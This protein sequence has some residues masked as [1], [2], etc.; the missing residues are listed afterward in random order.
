MNPV[1][2]HVR[3]DGFA[4]CTLTPELNAR[5]RTGP[6]NLKYD[7]TDG[8]WFGTQESLNLW[9]EILDFKTFLRR[10]EQRNRA[11]FSKLGLP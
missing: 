8:R 7:E 1:P 2:P 10:A 11:F 5:L 6:G 3:I 9:I 4:V